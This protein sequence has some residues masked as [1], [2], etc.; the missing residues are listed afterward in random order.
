MQQAGG[1]MRHGGFT[2]KIVGHARDCMVSHVLIVSFRRFGR[3][4]E[5]IDFV[6]CQIELQWCDQSLNNH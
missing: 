6:R 3:T 4:I 1:D 2:E 5:K